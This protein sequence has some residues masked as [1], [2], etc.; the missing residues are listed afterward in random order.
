M[1]LLF[2]VR[3]EKQFVS[4][5]DVFSFH[6]TQERVERTTIKM[7]KNQSLC[8]VFEGWHHQKLLN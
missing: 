2:Y 1:L 6:I 3:K 4:T 8:Q 7:N 5:G